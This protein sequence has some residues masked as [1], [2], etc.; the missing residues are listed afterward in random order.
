VELI[1]AN[2]PRYTR[3][4]ILEAFQPVP[5][6]SMEQTRK[7]SNAPPSTRAFERVEVMGIHDSILQGVPLEQMIP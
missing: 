3:D 6:K 1:S 2:G 7:K 5:E 4:Q